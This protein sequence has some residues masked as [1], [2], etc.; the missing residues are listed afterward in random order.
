MKEI[1]WCINLDMYL[2]I[3]FEK[4]KIWKIL[5]YK[6]IYRLRADVYVPF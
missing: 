6:E 2:K 1:T 3:N 5:V 4:G